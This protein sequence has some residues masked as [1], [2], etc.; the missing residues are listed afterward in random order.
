MSKILAMIKAFDRLT[1]KFT[2]LF[3]LL[4]IAV[5][6]RVLSF[7]E[8][9]WYGDEG[10]YL[11]IGHGLNQGKVLYRDIVDHKTP[12]IYYLAKVG[13][14]LNFRILLTAWMLMSYSCFY[15]LTNKLVKNRKLSWLI[16]LGFILITSLP[17]LEGLIPNGE[18]F[19]MGFI[20]LGLVALSKTNY[21]QDFFQPAEIKK[22]SP[23][24]KSVGW[25]LLSGIF[26]SLGI[27]TKVPAV[28]DAAAIF[29]I[30]WFNFFDHLALKEGLKQ[31]NKKLWPTIGTFFLLALAM[32]VPLVISASYFI[33]QG[34]GQD[35][36]QYG[37]LYNFHY[38]STWAPTI[39]T[40]LAPIWLPTLGKFMVAGGFIFFLTCL[41]KKVSPLIKW[42][43]AWTVLALA[44]STLSNRPYPHYL[45]QLV[46]PFTF[47]IAALFQAYLNRK[48]RLSSS[49]VFG[50]SLF[51]IV[52]V[53]QLISFWGYDSQKYYLNFWHYLTKKISYQTY[54]QSFD[55]LV[56][57][58]NQ[59]AQIIQKTPTQ[60]IYIWGTNP[61]LYAQTKTTPPDQFVVLFHVQDL[62]L[63]DQ[64]VKKVMLAKPIYVV[65]MKNAVQPPV[66][67][68]NF[69][70]N[71][72]IP[73]GRFEHFILWQ[74]RK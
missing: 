26:M 61:M 10:I 12:I 6:L 60:E 39:K 20:L 14:Q 73:I 66:L 47:L 15:F 50:F 32:A 48:Q 8:P 41:K 21:W 44:A 28:F 18:L 55:P 1:E 3:V 58:N 30:G 71:N 5:A 67:F 25:L 29:L 19:V 31:L 53:M 35:Y 46:L 68:T 13:S 72:Y 27:L 43:A 37:L 54:V 62:N 22:S 42:S 16:S 23:L 70:Q 69:I 65:V 59:A 33:F 63:V 24:V 38:T 45:L 2:G 9:Y 51:L 34:A 11:T 7:F 17:L 4:L 49:L 40:W 64:T 57:N 36:L 74:L 56:T 52:A